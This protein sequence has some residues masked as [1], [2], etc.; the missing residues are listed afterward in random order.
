[1]DTKP[2]S[3]LTVPSAQRPVNAGEVWFA[4]DSATVTASSPDALL[5]LIRD[6]GKKV[7]AAYVDDAD[8]GTRWFADKSYWVHG[9]GLRPFDTETEARSFLLSHPGSR[10]VDYPTALR[11][12]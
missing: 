10:I 12:A 7:R 1:V 4:G 5:R 2:L 8:T 6:S 9:D 11:L 3:S